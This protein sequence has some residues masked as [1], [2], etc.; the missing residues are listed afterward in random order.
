MEETQIIELFKK[1]GLN[2]TKA[3]E[4]LKNANLTNNLVCVAKSALKQSSE[5]EG[6]KGNLLYNI[7]SK[8]KS[9]ISNHIPLLGEYVALGKIDSEIRLNAAIGKEI[10]L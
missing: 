5:L 3:K 6:T 9:Q 7:A 2:E 8:T 1:I 4:T 10:F